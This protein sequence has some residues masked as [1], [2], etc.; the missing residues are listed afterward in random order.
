MFFSITKLIHV[1]YKILEKVKKKSMRKYYLYL[2]HW[3]MIIT[4]IL[5]YFYVVF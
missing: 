3:K 1:D 4:Q 2:K 5:I